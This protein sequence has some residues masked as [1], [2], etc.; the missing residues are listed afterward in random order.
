MEAICICLLGYCAV[1]QVNMVKCLILYIRESRPCPDFLGDLK[2]SLTLSLMLFRIAIVIDR[3]FWDT[4]LMM[5]TWRFTGKP[6]LPQDPSQLVFCVYTSLE[7]QN[8]VTVRTALAVLWSMCT[9][10]R[11]AEWYCPEPPSFTVAYDRN[12]RLI[13][14]D[15]KHTNAVYTRI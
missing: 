5:N 9:F 14:C 13:K 11:W 2:Y 10:I 6:H 7:Y 1:W 4:V 3:N 8:S 12:G 15:S